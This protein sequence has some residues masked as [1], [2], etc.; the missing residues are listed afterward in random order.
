MNLGPYCWPRARTGYGL[1]DGTIVDSTVHDGLW[2][3]N[4]DAGIMGVHAERVAGKHDVT[5]EAQDGSRP[6]SDQRALAARGVGPFAEE[7]SWS[8]CPA[9]RGRPSSPWTKAPR[10]DTSLEAL[11]RLKPA[12]QPEGGTVIRRQTCRASPTA[13]LP[14]PRLLAVV[15]ADDLARSQYHGVRPGRCRARV[16]LRSARSTAFG[17]SS[18]GWAARSTDFDLIEIN[19][20]FAAQVLA[21]RQRSCFDWDGHVNGGA[22]ALGH[23]NRRLG[24]ARARP[25]ALRLAAPRRREGPRHALPWRRGSGRH[26]GGRDRLESQALGPKRRIIG[27]AFLRAGQ[28]S[29]QSGV[30]RR[31]VA[32]ASGGYPRSP[33]ASQTR[34]RRPQHLGGAEGQ[35]DH[36]AEKLASTTACGACCASRSA[37]PTV[38]FPVTLDN[39]DVRAF[40]ATA[41][42]TTSACGRGKGGIRTAQDVSLDEVRALA[43]WMSWKCA[44]WHPVRGSQGRV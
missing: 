15:D 33:M 5:R 13:P 14:V 12:F 39:G 25:P 31:R 19:E 7:M 27:A 35:F 29:P 6:R 28:L 9:R 4:C 20:A 36:A 18:S 41:S 38:N 44:R 40:T 8:P 10:A 3:A 43:M 30:Q 11:P 22:I 32:C 42:S 17:A 37:K 24:S 16:A 23:P 1:G 21:R 34:S 26:G 2:C